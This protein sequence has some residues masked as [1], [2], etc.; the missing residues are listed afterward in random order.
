MWSDDCQSAFDKLKA[1]LINY[2]VLHSPDWTKPF[3]LAT[4]ASDVGVGAVLLQLDD[5]GIEHPISYFSKKLSLP[6][7]KY[8]TVEK[9]TLALIL[10]LQHFEVYVS[11]GNGPLEVRTDHNPLTFLNKFKSKNARLTRWSILLQEWDLLIKHVSGK[12]NVLPDTL[13]RL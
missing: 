6:Q 9:E 12:D 7:R 3:L 5:Q 4:D 1:I 2:P 8:S 10:A 11:G 13:S